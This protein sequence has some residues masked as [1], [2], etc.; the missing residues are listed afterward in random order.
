VAMFIGAG[1]GL[2]FPRAARLHLFCYY[3]FLG[4]HKTKKIK[5]EKIQKNI[6]KKS[7]NNMS[8]KRML[9]C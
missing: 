2:N 7:K 4:F 8:E 6:R 3:L 9:E 1:Q 5:N